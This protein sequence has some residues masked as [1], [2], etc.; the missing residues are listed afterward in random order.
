MSH[1][2]LE[3]QDEAACIGVD[4]E[5]FFPTR[6]VPSEPAKKICAGCPVRVECLEYAER[7]LL[8]H[9]VWGGLSERQRKERRKGRQIACVTCGTPIPFS[10]TGKYCEPCGVAARKERNRHHRRQWGAIE[11]RLA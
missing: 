8:K 3:W 4:P 6:G 5:I 11:A 1:P 9:G 7:E 2:D 10:P